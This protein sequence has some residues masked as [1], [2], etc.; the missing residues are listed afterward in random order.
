MKTDF[1]KHSLLHSHNA[2]AICKSSPYGAGD[3]RDIAGLKC[4]VLTSASSFSVVEPRGFWFHAKPAGIITFTWRDL[5]RAFHH[6]NVP[7]V[8]GIYLGFAEKVNIPDIP[9]PPMVT[10]DWCIN[11]IYPNIPK[12]LDRW[13]W[14]N[15]VDSDQTAP[16]EAGWSGSTL[17]VI[18][19]LSFGHI[20]Y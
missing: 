20:F 17:F 5:S 3:S 4:H 16:R 18:P 7:T 19:S 10:N 13:V 1:Q 2:P 6:K 9:W 11:N 14:V 12:F 15:S 8:P